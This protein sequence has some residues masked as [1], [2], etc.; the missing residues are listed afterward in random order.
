MKP[1]LFA[2]ALAACLA[3]AGGCAST[4]DDATT[5]KLALG[6]LDIDAY[7]ALVHPV[8][9][10]R[11]GSLDCH[12]QLPRGLRVYGQTGLRLPNDVGLVPGGGA[13]TLAEKRATY[14]SIVGLQPERTNELLL[15]EPRTPAD[16][17]QLSVLTKA[18][19][20]ERHRGGP[21]LQRGEP[22]EQCIVTWLVGHTDTMLC[23]TGAKSP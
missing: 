8:I 13:T 21:S 11:C 23:V 1:R 18:T 15:K 14:D 20:L 5:P 12:G 22:A 17:Y 10:R 4:P 16:A 7:V 3:S 6:P 19:A 2:F 9:E